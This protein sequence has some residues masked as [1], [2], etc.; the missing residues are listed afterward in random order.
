MPVPIDVPVWRSG[1]KQQVSCY[2]RVEARVRG[3]RE[4][5]FVGRGTLSQ[6]RPLPPPLILWL[7]AQCDQR[8]FSGDRLGLPQ[9]WIV[10]IAARRVW[11]FAPAVGCFASCSND[12][13]TAPGRW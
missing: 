13:Q 2:G 10:W 6:N 9:L 7:L 4:Y 5:G 8:V 3:R 12:S 11:L 1:C